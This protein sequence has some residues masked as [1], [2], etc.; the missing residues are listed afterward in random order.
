MELKAALFLAASLV[1]SLSWAGLSSAQTETRAF[2]FGSD[3]LHDPAASDQSRV[4]LWLHQLAEAG[5]QNFTASGING[6]TETLATALPPAPGWSVPDPADAGEAA[7]FRRAGYNTIIL[8]PGLALSTSPTEAARIADLNRRIFDWAANQTGPAR[9]FVFEDWAPA[10]ADIGLPQDADTLGAFLAANRGKMHEAYLAL[11]DDLQ[12]ALPDH[13]IRLI[14]VASVLA[15]AYE[16][17]PLSALD[18]TQLF[19]GDGPEATETTGLLAAMVSYATLFRERP[20]TL[21]LPDSIHPVLRAEYPRVATAIWAAVSGAIMPAGED[22]LPAGPLDNPWLGVGLSG[23]ADWS[24]QH[25]FIDLMKTARPWIGHTADQWGAWDTARLSSEGYLDAQGWLTA[26]P[27]ELDRVEALILTDQPASSLSAAGRYRISY[28]GQGDLTAA[29]LVTDLQRKPGEV[30][31]SYRPG[32]GLVAISIS[33]TDPSDP[34]RNITVIREDLIPAYEEGERFNPQWLRLIADMRSLRFVDYMKTNGSLQVTWQDRPLPEDAT[35]A[36]RGVPLEVMVDLANRVGADPWFTLPHMAD[37]AYVERF[38]TYVRDNLR[39]ALRVYAEWSNE[40]WNFGFPQ[41]QWALD[42]ATTRWGTAEDHAWMQFAGLRAAQVADIWA[43]VYGDDARD[44]LVRVVGTHTAWIGLEGAL[45]QAPLAQAEGLPPPY[46]SFDAYAVTGYFGHDIGSEETLP[47][48][49]EWIAAGHAT[50]TVTETLRSGSLH[51]LL[52]E[53][54]PYHARV[55]EGYNLR[56]VMY[57]GGTHLVGQGLVV[58]D[59]VVTDFFTRYNYSSEMA[60]LYAEVMTG[61]QDVGGTLFNVFVDVAAP[62]KWGSWGGLRH[63]DD[64][65]PRWATIRA[66]N[67]LMPVTW[68]TRTPGTFDDRPHGQD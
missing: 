63:L 18:G 33:A 44:R 23:I 12:R 21:T 3:P 25:P 13:D 37:D 64:M 24:P 54:W 58:D 15:Q 22:V 4:A 68:E 32:P 7:G 56:L 20:P 35:Y 49:R 26:I 61:W 62:S 1:L 45:L 8:T 36:L 42:Q 50:E 51:M 47:Q 66:F 53:L 46:S 5:G 34:I 16:T 19:A 17:S 11:L 29:G 28:E 39:P 27:P 55:A 6:T 31:F 41:A 60:G 59:Q 67:A 43:R 2:V 30:W 38:A 65:N 10:G 9:F 48:L 14:P 40:V 57:E 52:T